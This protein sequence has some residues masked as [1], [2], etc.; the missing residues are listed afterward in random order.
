MLSKQNR[1]TV[2]QFNQN[3]SFPKRFYSPNF[4]IFVKNGI[5][6]AAFTVSVPK[7]LDK[8]AVYRNQTKRIILEIIY[9]LLPKFKPF[10]V[11]VKPKKIMQKKERKSIEQE[12]NEVFGKMGILNI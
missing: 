8:R 2:S 1:I 4:Q 6:N 9:K 10:M 3:K 7:H 11:L 12:L 5:D